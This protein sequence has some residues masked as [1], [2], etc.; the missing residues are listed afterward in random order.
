MMVFSSAGG[1]VRF[2]ADSA[3]KACVLEAS[4][5]KPGNVSP[6][7]SFD[8]TAYADFVSA[9]HALRPVFRTAVESGFHVAVGKKSV[10]NA[11]IGRLVLEGVIEIRKSH[12]GG[13]THLGILL[14]F[15]PLLVASGFCTGV[16]ENLDSVRQKAMAIIEASSSEDALRVYDAIE[17]SNA[18]GLGSSELDVSEVESKNEILRRRLTFLDVMRL[19]SSWDDVAFELVNGYPKTAEACELIEKI[20]LEKGDLNTA[21]EQTFLV[22][23]SKYPDTLIARKNDVDTA[24][25][26]SAIAKDVLESGGVLT[27]VGRAKTK[28]LDV[29]LRSDGNKFNPGTTADITAAGLLI[30]LLKTK[31]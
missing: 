28:K 9:S 3:V 10:E 17:A 30:T 20:A 16:K 2:I 5:E 19:S 24:K 11:G 12:E 27:D 15:T 4:T 6:K 22:L 7:K 1:R 14:L 25:K 18:G 29:F 26:I 31:K 21:I 23:L 13:N 8:S